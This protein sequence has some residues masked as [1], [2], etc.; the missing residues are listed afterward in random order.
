MGYG[1]KGQSHSIRFRAYAFSRGNEENDT[2]AP[3]L[4]HSI[5]PKVQKKSVSGGQQERAIRMAN[6]RDSTPASRRL[7]A[8]RDLTEPDFE[9][10]ISPSKEFRANKR[11]KPYKF[12]LYVREKLPAWWE[13]FNSAL[14]ESGML[15]YKTVR[16]FALAKVK[17]RWQRELICEMLGPR[18]DRKR[19]RVPW[20]GDWKQRRMGIQAGPPLPEEIKTLAQSFRDKLVA[21]EAVRSA[22]P[23]LI[24]ELARYTKVS[25]EIDKVFAGQPLDPNQP[26]DSSENQARFRAYRLM[27]FSLT[28]MK[29]ELLN[30]WMTIHGVDPK[31]SVQ[32]LELNTISQNRMVS[33]LTSD[34]PWREMEL[35]K[36]ARALQAHEKNFGL[37]LPKELLGDVMD[38]GEAVAAKHADDRNSKRNHLQ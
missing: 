28:R 1:F 33:G 34:L 27:Q 26:P 6:Q 37:P 16:Q 21:V 15:K 8:L 22:A 23:F 19:L 32:V 12:Y 14:D 9:S 13:E 29:L 38:A 24:A 36:L 20:L 30:Q 17:N 3:R 25:E 18:P 10:P 2:D 31:D 4:D 5:Q 11:E 7:K 35:L